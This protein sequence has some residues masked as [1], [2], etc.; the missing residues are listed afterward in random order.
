MS[1][2]AFLDDVTD[3]VRA[4]ARNAV[5]HLSGADLDLDTVI[6]ALGS[7]PELRELVSALALRVFR[8]LAAGR[9]PVYAAAEDEMTPAEAARFLGVSRQFLDGQMAAG[10]LAFSTKPGSSH[11]VLTVS[12]VQRFQTRRE[13]RRASTDKAIA[14]LL[15]GG[16]DY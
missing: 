5:A 13:R 8:D 15:N 12:E 14:A 10:K 11:R 16:A 6:A 2:I 9:H 3:E 4:E 1:D 7:S